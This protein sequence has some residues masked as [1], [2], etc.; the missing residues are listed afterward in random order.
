MPQSDAREFKLGH[1]Q[2]RGRVASIDATLDLARLLN[3]S[4]EVM[5]H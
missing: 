1:Y 2:Q 5:T 3:V 4:V